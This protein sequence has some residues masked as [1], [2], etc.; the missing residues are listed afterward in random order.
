LNTK[1][2]TF[3]GSPD[4]ITDPIMDNR[5]NDIREEHYCKEARTN[6]LI[7]SR[8]EKKLAGVMK[9]VNKSLYFIYYQYLFKTI[10]FLDAI[11]NANTKEA[12]TPDAFT[13]FT[14]NRFKKT[15]RRI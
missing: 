5:D 13:L 11:V 1:C 4:I 2:L 10:F 9:R 12:S 14:N 3:L 8:M 6:R 15:L 7:I